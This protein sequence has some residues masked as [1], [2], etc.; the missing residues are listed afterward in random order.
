MIILDDPQYSDGWWTSRSGVP[1]ASQF[2]DIITPKGEPSKSKTK[3]LYRLATEKITGVSAGSDYASS[4]MKRG[5]TFEPEARNLFSFIHDV[6]VRQVGLCFPDEQRKWAASPDGLFEDTG[7]EIFCPESPNAVFCLLHPD[8]AIETA[9]KY[10]Q[11]Q[12][13]ML[14]GGFS[15]YYFISYYPGLPPLILLINR[16][17]KFIEKLK[18]ELEK[19]CFELA[20]ITAKLRDL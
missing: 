20:E 17:E 5:H 11:I 18:A 14:V 8:K 13:T 4:A 19:F 1:T 15:H 16:D 2:K 7:L 6:E 10:Q 9:D 12:G 3:Y